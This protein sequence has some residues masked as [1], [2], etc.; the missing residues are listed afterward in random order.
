MIT[1]YILHY[2]LC[3]TLNNLSTLK[4]F[5]LKNN[6]KFQVGTIIISFSIWRNLSFYPNSEAF[7]LTPR[8]S[9]AIFPTCAIT[10][11]EKFHKCKLASSS[12][13]PTPRCVVKRTR[14]NLL[15]QI[16]QS[17]NLCMRNMRR[18]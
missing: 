16:K 15:C 18:P 10:R 12:K 13:N 6:A 4:A 11:N 14:H 17:D 9:R 2:F 1:Y 7:S 5:N 3:F 8:D